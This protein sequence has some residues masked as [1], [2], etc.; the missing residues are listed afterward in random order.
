MIAKNV[1]KIIVNEL[2]Q[3]VQ[4]RVQIKTLLNSGPITVNISLYCFKPTHLNGV[5][6]PSADGFAFKI[7]SHFLS[8]IF[9]NEIKIVEISGSKIINKI[10]IIA[11]I[12]SKYGSP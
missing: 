10:N 12:E 9:V 11:G 7:G 5:V 6:M 2:A 8:L 1:P 3:N 4:I